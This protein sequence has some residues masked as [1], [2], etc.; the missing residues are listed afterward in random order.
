MP[1][2]PVPVSICIQDA[3]GG[4]LRQMVISHL[5]FVFSRD[6]IFPQGLTLL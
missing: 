1:S 6:L 4:M 2:F 3:I 5:R